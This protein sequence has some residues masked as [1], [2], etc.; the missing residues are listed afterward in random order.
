MV[1]KKR[2]SIMVSSIICM[3][4]VIT[5]CLLLINLVNYTISLNKMF[6]SN[7]KLNF[8]FQQ[9]L[10]DFKDN[11]YID[12][13]YKYNYEI[14]TSDENPNIKAVIYFTNNNNLLFYAVYDFENLETL[15]CQTDNFYITKRIY[16]GKEYYYLADLIRY[17]EVENVIS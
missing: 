8:E 10:V 11:S 5:L 17:K 7:Q 16:N 9:L 3:L 13:N 6:A 14:L 4:V 2:G 1:N 12:S 15:S